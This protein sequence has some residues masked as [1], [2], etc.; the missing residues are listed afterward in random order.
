MHRSLLLPV[1]RLSLG[2]GIVLD[3][4]EQ[5]MTVEPRDPS[6]R[7]EFDGL[8]R[9]PWRATTEQFGLVG[10]VDRFNRRSLRWVL[11]LGVEDHAHRTVD[12]LGREL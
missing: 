11:I 8:A 12:D 3:R 10:A 2:R 4:I 1:V 6:E 9:S 7:A 5:P